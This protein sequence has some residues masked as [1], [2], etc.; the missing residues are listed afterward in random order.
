MYHW[1]SSTIVKSVSAV[2]FP[3][4]RRLPA[5]PFLCFIAQHSPATNCKFAGLHDA[6]RPPHSRRSHPGRGGDEQP[7]DQLGGA[8]TKLAVLD[9]TGTYVGLFTTLAKAKANDKSNFLAFLLEATFAFQ[10]ETTGMP[11][12]L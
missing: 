4:R 7:D 8:L 11:L 1:T 12:A 5:N 3:P 9:K 6:L 10:F 2:R